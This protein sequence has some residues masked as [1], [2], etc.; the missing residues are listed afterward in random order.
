[1]SASHRPYDRNVGF[2]R[3]LIPEHRWG[4]VELVARYSH[5]DLDDKSVHGG[6]LDKGL[7]DVS[8]Y[9]NRWWR[10]G[11]A[12]GFTSLNRAGLIGYTYEHI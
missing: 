1:L 6:V 2:A 12:G 10:F 8:W 11:I 7:L 5:L 4:A 3:R 9:P